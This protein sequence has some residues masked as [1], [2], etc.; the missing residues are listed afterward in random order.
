MSK[1]KKFILLGAIILTL[2]FVI[3]YFVFDNYLNNQNQIAEENNQ[4]TLAKDK[5]KVLDDNFKI[6]LFKGD[7]K[8]RE[9][10]LKDMKKE[11]GLGDNITEEALRKALE[12]NGYTVD[13]VYDNEIS[14]KRSPESAVEPNKYY[15]REFDGYFA[16]YGSDKDG[17]LLIENPSTD[18]YNERK[19]FKDLPKSDQDIINR[20]DLKFNTKAEAEEKLSELIS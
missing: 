14:F 11:L 8:E 2:L 16:I 6:T 10:T 13:A 7:V 19:K 9:S 17:N 20:L 12:N 18:I 4:T 5:T 1:I 15:I 3:S